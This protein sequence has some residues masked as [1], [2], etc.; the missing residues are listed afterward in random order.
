MRSAGILLSVSSFSSMNFKPYNLNPCH[1]VKESCYIVS[2]KASFVKINE[3]GIDAAA[4]SIIE[5]N[6]NLGLTTGVEWDKCGWHFT[7]DGPL[8]CQYVFVMDALNFCFWP[9]PGL[10]YDTLAMSLKNVLDSDSSAF[11]AER[12]AEINEVRYDKRI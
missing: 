4:D 8:T 5:S 10:E 2:E 12:L 3:T 11:N 7:D 9:A 6:T 1:Q